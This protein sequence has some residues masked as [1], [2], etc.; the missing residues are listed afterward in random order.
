MDN[1]GVQSV[2]RTFAIIDALS[3]APKGAFLSELAAVVSL[4]KSTVHRLLA[5]LIMLGYVSKDDGT[6]KYLLTVKMFEVGSRVV[7]KL[8]MLT[9]AKPYLET[10]SGITGE[11]VHLVVRSGNEIVYIFKEDS[12]S[13]SVRMSSFIGM[14][15]PMYC[16][17]VGKSILAELTDDEA[18]D[19][20]NSSSVSKRT[21]NTIVTLTGLKEQLSGI[22]ST[23]YAVDN[24]ENESGI[25]CVGASILDFTGKVLGAFS[26][27]AP[28]G[29]MDDVRLTEIAGLVIKTKLE[30][31]AVLGTNSRY[32]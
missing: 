15:S 8:D 16:T 1:N 22:R 7:H 25:R 31:C 30:I 11:A 18:E 2:E 21:D 17:S 13:S 19:I 23:G 27:S 12:G 4:N 6:G 14:R 24:E 9:A 20:W 10:L 26:V 5:S 28:I 32:R 3:M 29:R